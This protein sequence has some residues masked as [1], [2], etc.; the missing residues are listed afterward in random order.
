[1]HLS[2]VADECIDKEIV[3]ALRNEGL[4]VFYVAEIAPSSSDAE[5]LEMA[6]KTGALLLTSDKD[7]GELVFRQR[8]LHSGVLLIRL[9][10]V[11]AQLK[12]RTVIVAVQE[13]TEELLGSFSVLEIGRLR[14]RHTPE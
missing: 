4:Q 8:R 6:T 14:I 9:S 12:A 7:F 2:I 13:H 3:D 11:V 1:M 5:V 10:G